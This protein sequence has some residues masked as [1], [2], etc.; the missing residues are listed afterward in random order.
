MAVN[1][2]TQYAYSVARIRAI[3]NHLLNKV[4][5]ERMLEA[6]SPG[7]AFKV[8]VEADYG[9]SAG[10]LTSPFEYEKL[11]AEENSKVYKLLKEIAPQPEAF[12]V[13]LMKND[14]HNIKVLLKAEFLGHDV[15]ELLIDAGTIPV[16]KMKL[17]IKERKLVELP[18]IMAHA[19]EEC[20]DTYNRT[21]DSQIIDII[22]DKANY[23][24]MMESA[25]KVNNPFL[26][27]LV[28]ILIDLNNIRTFLRVKALNKSF[29]FLQKVLLSG[30]GI[31][32]RLFVKWLDLS[33]E[34]LIA[35]L[36]YTPY[37]TICDDGIRYYLNKGSLT[38]LEKLSDDYVINYIKRAKYISL[39]IEPLIG[40]LLAKE[41]EI[42]IVRII[43]VGKINNISNE[44]IRERLREA[45]V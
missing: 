7:E 12:D 20:I 37:G 41:N 21:G 39:G 17:V 43:M 44:I 35:E 5:I 22:L 36:S 10:E 34:D 14:Y 29:D 38:R 31:R 25:Q 16:S 6:K 24:Q 11:L 42:K 27:D 33:Y 2:D 13:F 23:V 9:Y 45:Y 28:K 18:A 32:E 3:E 1:K 15:D 26:T 40:Y 4:K 8:L 19:V 30:G